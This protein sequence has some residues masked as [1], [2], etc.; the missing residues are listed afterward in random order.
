MTSD[1]GSSISSTATDMGL[2]QDSGNP[3]LQPKQWAVVQ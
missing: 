3:A 2:S 1:E